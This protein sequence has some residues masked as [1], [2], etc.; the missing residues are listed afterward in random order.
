MQRKLFVESLVRCR[1]ARVQGSQKYLQ[2]YPVLD[3]LALVRP[4]RALP[5][6]LDDRL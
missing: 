5:I 1:H 2:G 4:H 3:D 6:T